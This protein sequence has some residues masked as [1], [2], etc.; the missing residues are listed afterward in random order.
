MVPSNPLL[1]AALAVRATR[2]ASTHDSELK[3]K[4][5]GGVHRPVLAQDAGRV[6]TSCS[7]KAGGKSWFWTGFISCHIGP[8]ILW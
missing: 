3:P 8:D 4:L 6:L 1:Q 7:S 5:L 2:M